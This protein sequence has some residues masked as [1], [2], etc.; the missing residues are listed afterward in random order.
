MAK[1]RLNELALGYAAAIISAAAMLVLGIFGNL[2]I[3]AGAVEM[4]MKWHAFFSLSILG[5]IAGMIEAAVISFLAAYAFGW[6]Y[7]KLA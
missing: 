5:I 7:N 3:Y 1:S 2:R 6:V 4:M